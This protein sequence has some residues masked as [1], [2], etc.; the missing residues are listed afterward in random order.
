MVVCSEKKEMDGWLG[1]SGR[2]RKIKKYVNNQQNA[3]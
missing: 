3:L 2:K 1:K